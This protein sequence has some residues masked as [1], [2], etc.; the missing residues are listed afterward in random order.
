MT[1][2]ASM[3]GPEK[4]LQDA[5]ETVPTFVVDG[6][7]SRAAFSI[8]YLAGRIEGVFTR[9]SGS[10]LFDPAR[11]DSTAARIEVDT[12]SLD[13]GHPER[14]RHLRA[15]GF[16]NADRYPEIRFAS[17]AARSVSQNVIELTGDLTLHGAT[18]QIR[19][20]A[21]CISVTEPPE[22]G[23]NVVFDARAEISRRDFGISLPPILDLADFLVSDRIDLSFDI[24]ATEHFRPEGAPV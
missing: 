3:N 16:L 22:G 21:T 10:L 11:P 24:H 18:N 6:S 9:I 13:T 14:D 4:E 19:L 8:K 23:R 17:S 1:T 15:H 20:K 12:R 2:D 5:A 7:R